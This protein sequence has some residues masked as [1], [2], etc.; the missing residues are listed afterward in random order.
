MAKAFIHPLTSQMVEVGTETEAVAL[1]PSEP[2]M[3]LSTKVTITWSSCSAIVG[4]A[5][6]MMTAHGGRF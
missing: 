3:A 2:T 1:A 5:R 6:V 4:Q